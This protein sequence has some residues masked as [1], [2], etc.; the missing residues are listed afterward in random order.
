MDG[1]EIQMV[2]EF[3][4]CMAVEGQRQILTVNARAV[5]IDLKAVKTSPFQVHS[6]VGRTGIKAVFDEFLDNLC[7][8]FNHFSSSDVSDGLIVKL[9]NSFRCHAPPSNFSF[10][11][12]TASKACLGVKSSTFNSLSAWRTW[13]SSGGVLGC[14]ATEVAPMAAAAK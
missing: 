8:A 6:N 4:G 11:A 1:C 9:L 2:L 12:Y 3:G 10:N 7:W 5:V 14:S 13:A